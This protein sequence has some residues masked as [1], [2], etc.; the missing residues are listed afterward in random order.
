MLDAKL[1]KGLKGVYAKWVL[2]KVRQ[3]DVSTANRVDFFIANS[4]Y[5]A[6]RIKKIYNR[7]SIVIYP[8]VNVDDFQLKEKKQDYYLTAS[9]MV[10]YKK[11][12]IIVEAFNK[13][14]DKK[15]VVVGDGPEFSKIRK[16]AKKNIELKGFLNSKELKHYMQNAKAFI[17]AA[18]EDFG[19]VPVEA[20]ACGTPVIA[21]NAGGVRETVVHNKTGI[22]F[23]E[24]TSGSI[25]GALKDFEETDFNPNEIREN[26]L[27]FSKE[28]FE[29]EIK[30]YVELKYKEFKL[31]NN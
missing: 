3:W 28:R 6:Q 5:I 14:P 19:I 25:I 1:N 17:F 2:H 8:H 24:Q 27:R 30:E 18:K 16:I 26:A 13:M 31:N 4:N 29:K 9:R 10:P 22:L 15:L 11:I 21:Y 7:D 20:Q 12:Q 23:D